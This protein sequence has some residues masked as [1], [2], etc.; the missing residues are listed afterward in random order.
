MQTP[1]LVKTLDQ[2][3]DDELLERLRTVR[4]N[5]EVARPVAAK[6]AVTVE[7]KA[8]RKKVNDL[9]KL[10]AGMTEEERQQLIASLQETDDDN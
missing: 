1:Q 7:K 3:T 2:M 10:L 8:T 9:D 6:K 5:R 4:H